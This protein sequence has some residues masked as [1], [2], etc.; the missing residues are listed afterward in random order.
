[1]TNEP[2][3]RPKIGAGTREQWQQW[4]QLQEE[5]IKTTKQLHW[6]ADELQ[7][8]HPFV[9]A[10]LQPTNPHAEH[11]D[12]VRDAI[13]D[14]LEPTAKRLAKLHR[15]YTK[16]AQALREAAMRGEEGGGT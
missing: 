15:D 16:L 9:P 10:S 13:S 5:I 12:R 7:G 14:D 6:L 2:S 1:M 3:K 8:G 11:N 4:G